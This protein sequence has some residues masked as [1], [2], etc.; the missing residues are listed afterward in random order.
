[1]EPVYKLPYCFSDISCHLMVFGRNKSL[2]TGTF[3]QRR[4]SFFLIL[5]PAQHHELGRLM[6]Y[7]SWKSRGA[8]QEDVLAVEVAVF[9]IFFSVNQL[10]C[11][12]ANHLMNAR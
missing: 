1:M 6:D 2:V 10:E 9:F 7:T 3:C 8:F 11:I 12:F 5:A 4:G